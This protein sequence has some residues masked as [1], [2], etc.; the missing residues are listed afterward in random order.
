VLSRFAALLLPL[1]AVASRDSQCHDRGADG[2]Y[3][4]NG[5]DYQTPV[6]G[7]HSVHGTE[8]EIRA[9]SPRGRSYY[10][11]STAESAARSVARMKP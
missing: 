9:V 7:A 2:S 8:P 6:N 4:G 11:S 5:I 3:G 10:S 1:A